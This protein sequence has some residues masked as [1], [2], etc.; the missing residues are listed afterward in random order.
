MFWLQFLSKLIRVLRE[1][2]SPKAIAGGFTVGFLLGLTPL[3]SL[4]NLL[5]LLAAALLRMNLAALGFGMLLFSFVAYLFDPFFHNVGFFLLV[6]VDFLQG[7]YTSLYNLPAAPLTRFYNT[8]VAGSTVVGVALSPVVFWLA[9]HGI[10][11]YRARWAEKIE[12]SK[13]VRYLRGTKL[14]QWYFKLRDLE[15]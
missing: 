4:Q 11:N 1:G 8:I 10:E 9:K 14:V 13:I 2:D 5:L 6:Q 12:K 3:L 7:L 15:F